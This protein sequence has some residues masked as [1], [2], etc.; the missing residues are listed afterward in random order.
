[1]PCVAGMFK[2]VTPIKTVA[3]PLRKVYAH[4]IST[5]ACHKR[6]SERSP[7]QPNIKKEE[8]E[9][10]VGRRPI[11]DIKALKEAPKPALWLGVGGLVPFVVP[12]VVM[13]LTGYYV[14]QVH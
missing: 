12:P 13:L 8:S 14:P 9:K 4:V 1:M 6:W 5:S 2:A 7:N 11:M 3:T 10:P